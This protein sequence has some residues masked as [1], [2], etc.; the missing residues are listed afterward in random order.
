MRRA[1]LVESTSLTSGGP[2][3]L[4][5]PYS[6]GDTSRGDS[7]TASI[8]SMTG[9]HPAGNPRAKA[10]RLAHSGLAGSA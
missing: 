3:S 8:A 10:W 5:Q 9:I 1:R 6:S 7:A 2:R 4:D